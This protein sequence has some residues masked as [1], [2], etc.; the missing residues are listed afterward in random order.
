MRKIKLIAAITFFSLSFA[1]STNAQTAEQTEKATKQTE[2]MTTDLSLTGEQVTQAQQINLGIIM[3]N[4]AIRSS[5]SMTQEEKNNAI[6][7]N[8]DARKEMFRGILSEEQF[9]KYEEMQTL[10]PGMRKE[11]KKIE[12]PIEKKELENN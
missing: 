4:D 11:I 8:N 10:R 3:K 9:K 7:S 1:G 6:A 2:R 12:K 5:E